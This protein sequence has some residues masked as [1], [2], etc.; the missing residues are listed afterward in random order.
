MMGT[1]IFSRCMLACLQSTP[2]CGK[3]A[4][5]DARARPGG[6]YYGQMHGTTPTIPVSPMR[7]TMMW[8]VLLVYSLLHLS[9]LEKH[10]FVFHGGPTSDG[11]LHFFNVVCWPASKALWTSAKKLALM[12]ESDQEDNTLGRCMGLLRQPLSMISL[13]RRQTLVLSFMEGCW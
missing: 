7:R 12:Q 11:H 5:V 2:D 4:G 8:A 10:V 13:D 3:K 9:K 6:Q 1:F